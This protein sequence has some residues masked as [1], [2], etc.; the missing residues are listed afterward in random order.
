M[1]LETMG[2]T[3]IL[4]ASDNPLRYSNRAFIKLLQHG[5]SVIPVA[6]KQIT[7]EN[8]ASF[9]DIEQVTEPVDTV[10]IYLRPSLLSLELE[11]IIRLK[12]RR[13]IF[14]PGTESPQAFETL[15]KSGI[16]V[17]Q[18]CTLIMLGNGT[19]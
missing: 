13:V 10:T 7:I 8:I 18:D 11:K 5:H 6:A 3:L 19:Y 1:L 2:H 9:Q 12:P 16:E 4:G 15:Q 17:V 14:N